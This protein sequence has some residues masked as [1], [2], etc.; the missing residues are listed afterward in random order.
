[1]L[2]MWQIM[3]VVAVLFLI[4]EI[5]T[6]AMFFLNLAISAVIV[7]AVSLFVCDFTFNIV[8]FVILSFVLLSVLRPILMNWKSTENSKTGIEEKYI[9]KVVKVTSDVTKT[10]GV[11]SIYGE[12][13]EARVDG[14]SIPAGSDA[15]IVRNESLIMFVEKI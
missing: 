15:R 1:M 13:W 6:P 9:G 8:L 4:L 10:S 11:I 2:S 3:L 5:F 14:E 7:S 12:R